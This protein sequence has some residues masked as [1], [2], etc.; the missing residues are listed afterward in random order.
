MHTAS[1]C[2]ALIWS[3]VHLPE[4]RDG[5][6]CADPRRRRRRPAHP[7]VRPA[8]PRPA[9]LSDL[10]V[11][12]LLSTSSRT[13]S[14]RRQLALGRPARGTD[15]VVVDYLFDRAAFRSRDPAV[16]RGTSPSPSSSDGQVDS[17]KCA[18][19]A[20]ATASADRP[21]PARHRPRVRG[22][23]CDAA[24][25]RRHDVALK[26]PEQNANA[27]ELRGGGA[28]DGGPHRRAVTALEARIRSSGQ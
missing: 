4:P 19:S 7:V 10:V 22:P 1:R 5:G 17:G 2:R 3:T 26:R 12:L 13:P 16:P 23:A 9:N 18:V 11:V 8:D 24:A 14:R 27:G 21:A 20:S 6:S 28:S 25:R 15:A